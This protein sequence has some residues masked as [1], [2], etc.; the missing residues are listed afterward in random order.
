M[1]G[2]KSGKYKDRRAKLV[3]SRIY[4]KRTEQIYR[5]SSCTAK[6]ILSSIPESDSDADEDRI[7]SKT[8]SKLFKKYNADCSGKLNVHELTE[9]LNQYSSECPGQLVSPSEAEVLW[10]IEAAG[11]SSK[12]YITATELELALQLWD[13]YV[14][15]R[16][17]IEWLSDSCDCSRGKRLDFDQLKLYLS[18]LKVRPP[19]VS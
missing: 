13:S 3:A 14:E 19:K 10:I 16:T 12:N 17:E 1:A 2:V 18:N 15:H 11:K 8:P 6:N 4:A 7:S 9:L 5:S